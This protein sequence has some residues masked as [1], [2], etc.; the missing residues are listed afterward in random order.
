MIL[1]QHVNQAMTQPC[2]QV[3]SHQQCV[4][5]PMNRFQG[6]GELQGNK[7]DRVPPG[8]R[9]QLAAP[10]DRETRGLQGV[11]GSLEAEVGY[12]LM[13]PDLHPECTISCTVKQSVPAPLSMRAA[14]L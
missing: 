14:P 9:D 12:L 4:M 3:S 7:A 13:L 2:Q 11:A 10:G 8:E 6:Q 1:G 5:F